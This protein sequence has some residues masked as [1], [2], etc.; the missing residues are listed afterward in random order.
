MRVKRTSREAGLLYEFLGVKGEGRDLEAVGENLLSR[1]GWI[2]E[3]DTEGELG[4]ALEELQRS[5]GAASAG[6]SEA[7]RAP[8]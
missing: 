6:A 7:S 8:V 2:W 3:W 4:S 1:M 5:E